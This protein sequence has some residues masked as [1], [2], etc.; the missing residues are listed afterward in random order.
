MTL[1]SDNGCIFG[2]RTSAAVITVIVPP[3]QTLKTKIPRRMMAAMM[4][5]LGR[6]RTS[7]QDIHRPHMKLVRTHLVRTLH[8]H[9][10][11]YKST[12]NTQV[13]TSRQASTAFL[14]KKNTLYL[15]LI[16]LKRDIDYFS[17]GPISSRTDRTGER[18]SFR[19]NSI[20]SFCHNDKHETQHVGQLIS[21]KGHII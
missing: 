9:M 13:T 16:N 20:L 4:I 7:A 17:K 14:A 21:I 8:V 3:T 1:A 6:T 5:A 19:V 11:E 10:S 15:R 12:Y 2:Q 18:R